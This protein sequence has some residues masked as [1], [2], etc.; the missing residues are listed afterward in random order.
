[1]NDTKSATTKPEGCR[2]LQNH[3]LA[4]PQDQPWFCIVF[5]GFPA[6]HLREAKK[7]DNNMEVCH[8]KE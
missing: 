6:F 5:G 7:S 2:T 8:E 4:T 3:W 1:V